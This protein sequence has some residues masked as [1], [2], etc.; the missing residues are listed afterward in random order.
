MK[1]KW[2]FSTHR[3][4]E[5][6]KNE[7][8]SPYNVSQVNHCKDN[9]TNHDWGKAELTKDDVL[10]SVYR[11]HVRVNDKAKSRIEKHLSEKS[12][13]TEE[14]SP[15]AI[16]VDEK[17]Y[18]YH[19]RLLTS[20]KNEYIEIFNRCSFSKLHQ[21]LLNKNNKIIKNW[22]YKKNKI[23][24][25]SVKLGCEYQ[26]SLIDAQYQQILI[27]KD[28]FNATSYSGYFEVT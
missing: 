10:Q 1:T 21:V 13:R 23:F 18:T 19:S 26:V 9:L 2:F 22:K 11:D 15:V 24:V 3:Y 20:Q 6:G 5:P 17:R 7:P 14:Y 25:I 8:V 4:Q 27:I 28:H 16:E 12:D